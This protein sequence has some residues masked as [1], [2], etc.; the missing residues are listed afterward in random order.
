[1]ILNFLKN[2]YIIFFV[3]IIYKVVKTEVL[4]RRKLFGENVLQKSKSEFFSATALVKAGN[5]W[6]LNEGKP[7][8]NLS[9]WFSL[10]STKEFIEEL[11]N[12]YGKVVIKGRGRGAHIW[13]HPLLFID[14]ALAISPKLKVEVYEWLLDKLIQNRNDSGDSYKRMCGV[15]FVRH[16][17]KSTFHDFIRGLALKIQLYCSVKDWQ[18]ATEE[19]LS[20]RNRIHEGITWVADS[21]NN[22]EQ[23]IEVVFSKLERNKKLPKA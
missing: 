12:K 22:N 3:S 15:L 5:K 14:I 17:N 21:M 4:M 11:E 19:Q 7:L 2:S 23:A 9:Q 6:R 20:L 18:E 13:V 16:K 8:F 10:K 1:M